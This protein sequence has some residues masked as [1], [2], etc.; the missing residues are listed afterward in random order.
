M[1]PR[2]NAKTTT[3]SK[4]NLAELLHFLDVY[5]HRSLVGESLTSL[6]FDLIWR[7]Q[8]HDETKLTDPV[9]VELFSK[10]PERAPFGSAEYARRVE[11]LSPAIT[12]HHQ[13]ERHHV[14]HYTAMGGVSAMV[15]NDI[16]ELIGDYMASAKRDGTDVRESLRRAQVRFKMDPQLVQIMLNTVDDLEKLQKEASS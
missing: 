7:A 6:A 5:R 13:A 10:F 2:K 16:A 1:K 9:Q 15:I 4:A 11:E 14:E 8:V 3:N 12:R